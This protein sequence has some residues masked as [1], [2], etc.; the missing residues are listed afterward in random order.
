MNN[1]KQPGLAGILYA[2]DDAG[3]LTWSYPVN[4]PPEQWIE[5]DVTLNQQR[6]QT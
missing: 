4:D 3:L 2:S 5:G 1:L 6:P